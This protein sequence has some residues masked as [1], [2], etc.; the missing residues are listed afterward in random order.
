MGSQHTGIIEL[1]RP[2]TGVI[3][4]EYVMLA[5]LKVKWLWTVD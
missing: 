2:E 5:H 1:F 3:D 4:V